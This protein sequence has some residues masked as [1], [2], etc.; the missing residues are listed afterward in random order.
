[1]KISVITVCFNSEATLEHAIRS[2]LS[3]EQVELEYIVIDG[4]STDKT[5]DILTRYQSEIQHLVSEPDQGIYFALNKGI[6]LATGEV[7]GILHS[8]DFYT[9]T[10]VLQMVVEKLEKEGSDAVYGDL[11]YV[12]RENPDKIFRNW[13]SGPYREGLF[14]QG[15]MPPHPVFF[16]R[17]SCYL[18]YGTFNTRFHSAADYELMLRFIQKHKIKLSYIPQV[19]V[20]MRTGGKSNVSLAN[21]WKANREDRLAWKINDLTPGPFTLIYKPLSK[22]FQFF[23]KKER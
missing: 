22:L 2:V 15:W 23:G 11:Q 4:G 21:R 9:S 19:L 8:D 5:K 7:I 17:R 14:L 1:M 18:R 3:Q 20:K 13:I 16:V 6:A 10:R 12:H